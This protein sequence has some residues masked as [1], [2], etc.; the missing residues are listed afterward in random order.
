MRDN[1]SARPF[2][3]Y[4]LLAV[5]LFLALGG[6]LGGIGLLA[7]PSGANLTF[8]P[9]MLEG[10]PF[11]DFLIPGLFLLLVL[12]LAPLAVVYGLWVRAD[13]AWRGSL[14]VSL[15]L[16]A[17]VAV[18]VA[19]IGYWPEPPLQL[20]FGVVGLLLLGLTLLPTIRTYAGSVDPSY[21]DTQKA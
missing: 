16:L 21:V 19:V 3:L 8:S 6:L 13:W 2:P 17:F 15:G 7:D 5:H 12:G 4:V 20:V 9:A 11:A 14:L 18:E 1:R 10:S